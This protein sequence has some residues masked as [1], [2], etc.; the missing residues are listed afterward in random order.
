MFKLYDGKTMNTSD[1]P[2]KRYMCPF[3]VMGMKLEAHAHMKYKFQQ[4]RQV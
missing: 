2:A 3:Y 1:H 4:K